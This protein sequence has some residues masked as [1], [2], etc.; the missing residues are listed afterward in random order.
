M[1]QKVS[2]SSLDKRFG[3]RLAQNYGNEKKQWDSGYILK[4]EPER[5][6]ESWR[7]VKDGFKVSSMGTW[8]DKL[9]INRL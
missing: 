6:T 5:F 8:K 4:G 9:V 7:D 3:F 2:C 1:Y